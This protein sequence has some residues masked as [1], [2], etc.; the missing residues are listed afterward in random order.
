M[1][2]PYM[3]LIET[4]VVLLW[5]VTLK[6][7]YCASFKLNLDMNSCRKRHA[8]STSND[9]FARTTDDY[10]EKAVQVRSRMLL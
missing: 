4:S 1:K 8:K 5:V 9:K 10:H 7:D 2:F 6:C 3:K